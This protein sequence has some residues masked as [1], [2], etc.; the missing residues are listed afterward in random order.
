MSIEQQIQQ[1]QHVVA[2][3]IE[4]AKQDYEENR[5]FV[6]ES[7]EDWQ[8]QLKESREQW[9]QQLEESKAEWDR[10]MSEMRTVMEAR[11]KV[12]DE[13]VEKLVLA[14]RELLPGGR[15]RTAS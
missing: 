12:A 14:I 3:H 10:G 4:Q 13:R 2:S 9:Q 8:R 7:R 6:R 15:S 1:M 5:R 11:D